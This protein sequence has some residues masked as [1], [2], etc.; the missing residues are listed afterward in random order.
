MYEGELAASED[1]SRVGRFFHDAPGIYCFS[2]QLK[3]NAFEY[4]R[5]VPLRRYGVFWCAVWE[6]RVDRER[7]VPVDRLGTDQ[8]VQKKGSVVLAALWIR[9]AA[10]YDME[11]NTEVQLVWD[12]L[13]EQNPMSRVGA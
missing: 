9:C 3:A 1:E 11:D 6:L 5:W 7:R 12:P 8:W 10:W 2:D 4:A 13:L